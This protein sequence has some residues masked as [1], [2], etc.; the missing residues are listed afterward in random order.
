MCEI[1]DILV[2]GGTD[3]SAPSDPP[4]QCTFSQ[5]SVHSR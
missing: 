2:N 5:F 3:G 1:K 4:L